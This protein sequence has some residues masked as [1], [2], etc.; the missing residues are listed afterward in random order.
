MDRAAEQCLTLSQGLL[1][2]RGWI[3][4]SRSS[5][6]NSAGVIAFCLVCKEGYLLIL[7]L[8]SI[9]QELPKYLRGYHAC[10]KEEAIQNAAFLYRV[11]FGDDKS[12]FVH[13]PKMLKDL[14]PRDMVRTMSSEEWK[15]SIVAVCNRHTG[16]TEDEVKLAFLKQL[17][18]LAT[19]GSAFFEVKQTSESSFPDIVRIAINKQGVTLINPQTKAA[20]V[21]HPFNKISNWCSGSTYFHMSVGNLVRGGKLLCE[22]SL[23]YKMDDLLTSYVRAYQATVKQKPARHL[24]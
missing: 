7:F 10:T 12:Q 1:T 18:R 13:I 8:F 9:C 11:K 23:G 16:K 22:T 19:F 24:A 4:P 21:T 5:V 20:L 2:L 6:D 15:K 14:V 17:S 3:Q